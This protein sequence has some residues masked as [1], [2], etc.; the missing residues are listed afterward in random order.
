DAAVH[1]PSTRRMRCSV[2]D[3]PAYFRRLADDMSQPRLTSHSTRFA[4]IRD[5][6]GRGIRDAGDGRRVPERLD[7]MA[8]LL[9]DEARGL[10]FILAD[11]GHQLRTP[12]NGVVGMAGVL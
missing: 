2:A 11:M 3:F 6:R 4:S 5:L 9:V 8:S 12:L 10:A 1:G 7:R